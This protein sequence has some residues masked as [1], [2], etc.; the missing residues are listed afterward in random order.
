LPNATHAWDSPEANGRTTHMPWM[1]KAGSFEYSTTIT[2][3]SRDRAFTFIQKAFTQ[4]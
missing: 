3:T 1:P 2:E 4:Q